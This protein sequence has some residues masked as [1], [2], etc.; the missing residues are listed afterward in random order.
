M[1]IKQIKYKFIKFLFPKY[2]G[3]VKQ[4]VKNRIN[5][6][7]HNK[8]DH[9]YLFILCS[10]YCG[11]TLMNQVVSTSKSVSV[12]NTIITREGQQIP[13]TK[14]IMFQD[15]RWDPT[16]EYD[17][18]YIKKIWMKYWDLR[19]P[20]LLEKSPPNLLRAEKI[21]K[22]FQPIYFIIFFRNPYAHCESLMRR[23]DEL[24][25]KSAAEF[26]IKCLKFQKRNIETLKN[27]VVTS[28]EEFT[29]DPSKFINSLTSL[30]P[31]LKDININKEFTAHNLLNKGKMKIT[32][33]NAEK[34]KLISK[35]D[36]KIIN[37]IFK[38]D[39]DLLNYFNYKIIKK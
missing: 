7:F 18:H 22:V 5:N 6:L 9:K 12:N 25:A 34:I 16:I 13:D 37:S 26:A 31:E 21:S 19:K 38:N 27:I 4:L 8:K 29:E 36:M 23:W 35:S 20:I 30:L 15:N 28:Y 11:S 17:W 32:N 3:F 2:A 39:E 1:N 14:P 10:K 24:D 33:L